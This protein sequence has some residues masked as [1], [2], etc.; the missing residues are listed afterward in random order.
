MGDVGRWLRGA[1]TGGTWTM[2]IGQWL[3]ANSLEID[4]QPL[5]I[6]H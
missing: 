4:H 1:R 2:D 3:M 5:A 6:I